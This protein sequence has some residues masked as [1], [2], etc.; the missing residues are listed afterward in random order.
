LSAFEAANPDFEARVRDSFSRQ[1][2][3]SLLGAEIGEL[4]PG[5][6]EIRLDWRKDLTQQHGYFHGGII[7]ALADDAA[8][9]AGFTLMP[10]DA[11][12]LTVEYK[13]NLL[14]PGDGDLLISRSR[15]IRPGRTLTVAQSDVSVSK[16]GRETLCA[17]ALVTLFT[18]HGTPDHAPGEGR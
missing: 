15:V 17:T 6:C 12:L 11:S 16:E 18:L 3:M 9:Y 13:L 14:A 8:G 7:G 2:F 1:A 4:K 10:A 5:L